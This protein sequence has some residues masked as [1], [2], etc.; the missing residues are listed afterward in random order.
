MPAADSSPRSGR[1]GRILLWLAPVLLVAGSLALWVS[2]G[3]T[4]EPEGGHAG[5][6]E[7]ASASVAD[8]PLVKLINPKVMSIVRVVGQPSFVESYDLSFAHSVD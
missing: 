3:R 1:R 7:G 5:G 8:A 4:G 2:W 6:Q